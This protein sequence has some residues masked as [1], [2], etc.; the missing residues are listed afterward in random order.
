MSWV[1]FGSLPVYKNWHY[2]YMLTNVA[3]TNALT[4]GTFQKLMPQMLN[5]GPYL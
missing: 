3:Y 1:E 2:Q 4:R 5:A